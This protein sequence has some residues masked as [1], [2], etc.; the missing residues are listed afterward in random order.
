MGETKE[1][2]LDLAELAD[3]GRPLYG[4]VM[5]ITRDPDL[6]ADLVQDTHVRAVGRSQQYRRC[7]T[8]MR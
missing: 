2:S 3:H 6:A 7:A 8:R 1:V 5:S 4:F